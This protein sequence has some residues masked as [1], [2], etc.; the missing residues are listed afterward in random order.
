MCEICYIEFRDKDFTGLEC[1]HRFCSDCWTSYLETKIT[2]DGKSDLIKCAAHE[3]HIL[4]NDELVL[5]LIKKKDVVKR[6]QYLITNSFVEC[7]KLMAWCPAPTSCGNAVKVDYAGKHKIVCTCKY[8]F[9]FSCSEAWHDPLPCDLLKKWLKKC[10][11]ESETSTWIVAHTKDCPKCHA[12][13]EKNGG[14][15]HMTCRKI[16]C[17]HHFCWICLGD[18]K[19]HEGNAYNCNRYDE[20]KNKKASDAKRILLRYLHY[21]NLYKTHKQSLELEHN[22]YEEV[23][24]KTK[25]LQSMEL[26]WSDTQFMKQAV[27][28]LQECRLTLL[29]TYIFAFY[30][31]ECNEQIIFED[32]QKDLQR[33]I[34]EL[35]GYLENEE[36][37]GDVREFRRKVMNL[38]SYCQTRRKV[39]VDHV[40]EGY[41]RNVWI[42]L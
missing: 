23:K 3:C 10:Q 14:C 38:F 18:W 30:L 5:R 28:V 9:C 13:I 2:N 21:F 20:A 40:H 32:N 37:E 25:K 24:E 17:M 31:K 41:D 7:N 29:H 1:G 11:D 35:S 42:T 33:A 19:N 12:P 16:N 4:V 6:Y 26:S 15:N 36:I 8:E 34:E 27:D 39:L 22:L